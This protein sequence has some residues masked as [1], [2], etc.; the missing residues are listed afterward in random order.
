VVWGRTT[1]QGFGFTLIEL[2]VV[3]AIIA[4][5]ASLLLPGLSR[6]KGL[7]Y[8]TKCASNERQ[9]G[10]GLMLYAQDTAHFPSSLLKKG[11]SAERDP[12]VT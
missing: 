4:L 12:L 9:M 1:K 3:I 6:A 7:A 8:L 5:L 10:L 2:L 11:R